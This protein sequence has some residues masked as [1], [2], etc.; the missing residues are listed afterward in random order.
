MV[1]NRY[2][3]LILAQLLLWFLLYSLIIFIDCMG[4]NHINVTIIV[5][6]GNYGYVVFMVI[7]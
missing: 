6:H 5:D 1:I 3:P 7:R 2:R 4:T